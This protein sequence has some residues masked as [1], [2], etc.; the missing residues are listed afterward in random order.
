MNSK[1]PD[2]PHLYGDLWGRREETSYPPNWGLAVDHSLTGVVAIP[3]IQLEGVKARHMKFKRKTAAG[4]D[5]V[6]KEDISEQALTIL[7]MIFNCCSATGLHPASWKINRTTLIPKSGKDPEQVANW[8]PITISSVISRL[9]FGIIDQSLRQNV[10]FCYRQKGGKACSILDVSKTFDAVPHGAL[11]PA[12]IRLGVPPYIA[13][14]ISDSCR[15]EINGKD[16]KHTSTT[17]RKE[18]GQKVSVLTFADDLTVVSESV[19][20]AAEDILKTVEYFKSLGMN[21]SIPKCCSFKIRAMLKTWAIENPCLKIKGEEVQYMRPDQSYSYLGIDSTPWCGRTQ[22]AALSVNCCRR[23]RGVGA[24]KPQQKLKLIKNYIF[25]KY[26]YRLALDPP[27]KTALKEADNEFSRRGPRWQSRKT[28]LAE[29]SKF[30]E[31]ARKS[32]KSLRIQMPNSKKECDLAK[33]QAKNRELTAWAN[34]TSQGQGASYNRGN[35]LPNMWLMRDGILQPNRMT[36]ALGFRTITFGNRTSLKRA[37]FDCPVEYR[38]CK[39]RPKCTMRIV[40]VSEIASKFLEIE[41]YIEPTFTVASGERFKPDLVM[42]H[43][44]NVL[45]VD[46][47]VR[48]EDTGTLEGAAEEKKTK[49]EGIRNVAREH[50]GRT[51]AEVITIVVGAGGIVPQA[52]R[53]ALGKLTRTWCGRCP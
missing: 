3:P 39:L 14:Y 49:Y 43:Q 6:C 17:G 22:G 29:S 9:Y 36:V 44:E 34:Q 21:S 37:G 15:T 2:R 1:R 40:V 42:K 25:P 45:I 20:N 38:H 32:D 52:T 13:Q 11:N 30:A 27:T 50:L 16:G 23:V 41:R 48:Y 8:L 19:E 26:R 18:W 12:L 4:P 33:Q 46:F 31:L 53:T 51:Y 35:G 5:G 24:L 7:T 28:L 10:K 47:A